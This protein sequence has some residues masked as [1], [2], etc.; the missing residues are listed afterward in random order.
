MALGS[1]RR[2]AIAVCGSVSVRDP[3]NSLE[4]RCLVAV[5]NKKSW[6]LFKTDPLQERMVS[7]KGLWRTILIMVRYTCSTMWPVI[8]WI[9]CLMS[10]E[11]APSNPGYNWC[12][13]AKGEQ[14]FWRIILFIK[15]LPV[16]SFP[17]T[18]YTT[19]INQSADDIWSISGIVF[20]I[21]KKK[22][23]HLNNNLQD[24]T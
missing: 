6:R 24:L 4:Y 18:L 10:V 13:S 19:K 2:F 17:C 20:K 12:Y 22:H 8:N 21:K 9:N 15:V 3:V 1:F 23:K 7:Q 16:Y 5:S 14:W 11:D